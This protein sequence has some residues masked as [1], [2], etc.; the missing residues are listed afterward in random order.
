[1]YKNRI[2]NIS[3]SSENMEEFIKKCTNQKEL[4]PLYLD[5]IRNCCELT[6]EMLLKIADFDSSSKMKI[7]IEYN[8]CIKIFGESFN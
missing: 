4:L 5:H 2:G 7:I 1:M 3:F 8:R 6:E